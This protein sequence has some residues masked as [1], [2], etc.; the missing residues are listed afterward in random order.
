MNGARRDAPAS[1]Q[2]GPSAHEP[3]IDRHRALGRLTEVEALAEVDV[4][5]AHRL[6]LADP[7]DPLGD[8]LRLALVRA[9]DERGD[10]PAA[11]AEY[12]IPAVS[13]LS[14]LAKSGLSASR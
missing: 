14:I 8:Y 1:D 7:L 3:G 11:A 13:L 5:V 6:E 9:L 10:E 2:L 4:E 12:W